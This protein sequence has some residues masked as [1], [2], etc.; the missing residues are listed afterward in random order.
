MDA[1]DEMRETDPDPLDREADAAA[2]EA[3]GIGGRVPEQDLDPAARPV[4]EGG[5]G[6]AE[7]FELAEEA[8]IDNAENLDGGADPLSDAFTAEAESDRAGA[9]YGEA[10]EVESTEL[11]EDPDEPDLPAGGPGLSQAT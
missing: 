6:E 5:G 8:L 9:E 3:G 2:A 1:N 10:D 11:V 4:V 7:G